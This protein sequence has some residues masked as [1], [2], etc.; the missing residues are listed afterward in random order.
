V[1]QFKKEHDRRGDDATG[2]EPLVGSGFEQEQPE[3]EFNG[4]SEESGEP[5]RE[6]E[7]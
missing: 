7:Q 1:K 3:T 6:D 4:D 5:E 2:A